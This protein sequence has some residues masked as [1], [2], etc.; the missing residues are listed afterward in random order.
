MKA[1]V[2]ELSTGSPDWEETTAE[3]SKLYIYPMKSCRGIK[4][5]EANVGSLFRIPSQFVYSQFIYCQFA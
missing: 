3:V 4:V 5:N 1:F 2:Q